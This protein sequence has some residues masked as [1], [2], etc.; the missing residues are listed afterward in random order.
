MWTVEKQGH[1]MI[2]AGK[3]TAFLATRLLVRGECECYTEHAKPVDL[4]GYELHRGICISRQLLDV[5]FIHLSLSLLSSI[6]RLLG[7]GWG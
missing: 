6:H 4:R 1:K 2:S 5:L 3:L 7:V